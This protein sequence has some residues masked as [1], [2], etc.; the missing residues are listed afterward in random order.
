MP[1]SSGLCRRLASTVCRYGTSR[2][3]AVVSLA[4]V[5]AAEGGVDGHGLAGDAA[6]V[7][8]AW[9]VIRHGG[10]RQST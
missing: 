1:G 8:L 6:G 2:E 10:S 4:A 7:V 5:R 9:V 3:S